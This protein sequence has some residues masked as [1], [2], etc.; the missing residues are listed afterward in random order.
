[1][2]A[3]AVFGLGVNLLLLSVLGAHGHSHGG[4][5]GGA[6]GHAHAH[7]SGAPASS[8]S[9]P[10]HGHDH[11]QA[12]G[13]HGHAVQHSHSHNS[14]G[15]A[16]G[17]QHHSCGAAAR[18]DAEGKKEGGVVRRRSVLSSLSS[19]SFAS[20]VG[21]SNEQANIN[22]RA[23]ALHVVGDLVQSMGVI[24]ASVVVWYAHRHAAPPAHALVSQIQAYMLC[25]PRIVA[26]AQSGP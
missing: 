20:F 16:S 22:V 6:H 18:G 2:F 7:G 19:S 26:V 13:E 8:S 4:G 1:M 10:A 11:N 24:L 17:S 25:C 5:G 14:S 15:G 3:V 23:A 9:S 12:G 21:F